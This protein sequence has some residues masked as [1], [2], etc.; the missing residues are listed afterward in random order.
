MT[1]H[2][3]SDLHNDSLCFSTK[4][5]RVS[6]PGPKCTGSGFVLRVSVQEFTNTF[7]FKLKNM[8]VIMQMRVAKQCSVWSSN[9][10]CPHLSTHDLQACAVCMLYVCVCI[11][12]SMYV[13][14]YV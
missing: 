7:F 13:C 4:K 3:Y 12:I 1:S 2:S 14:M 5:T 9:D 6:I 10:V 11:Y 8:T